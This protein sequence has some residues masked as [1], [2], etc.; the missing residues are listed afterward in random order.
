MQCRSGF[1]VFNEEDA[2]VKT[3]YESAQW[4]YDLCRLV[5][6]HLSSMLEG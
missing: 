1:L 5:E 6:H 2:I 4:Q 3:M